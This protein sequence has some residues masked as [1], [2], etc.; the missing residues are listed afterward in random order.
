[1]TTLIV[2]LSSNLLLWI[3]FCNF[4]DLCLSQLGLW[5]LNQYI[6]FVAGLSRRKCIPLHA[7]E[8]TEKT[9]CAV[10]WL[11]S[12]EELVQQCTNGKIEKKEI[13]YRFGIVFSYCCAD[14]WNG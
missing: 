9:V 4:I 12:F 2:G 14:K 8:R 3:F 5:F 11:D 6:S 7:N 10:W 1:M 13:V